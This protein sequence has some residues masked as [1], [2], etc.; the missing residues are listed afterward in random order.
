MKPPIYIVATPIG[1][2]SD[3]SMRAISVIK[4]SDC[5]VCEDTRRTKSLLKKLEIPADK[6][7]FSLFKGVEKKR[8]SAII[9]KIS[10][11]KLVSF[12]SDSGTPLVSDP[13]NLFIREAIKKGFDVFSIPGASAVLSALVVSGFDCENFVFSGF[14][15][16][17]KGEIR[18]KLSPL[19][20]LPYTLVFFISPHRLEK[21]IEA[22]CEFFPK[23]DAVLVRELTKKFEEKIRGKLEDILKLVRGKKLKGEFVIVIS[24]R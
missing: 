22:L 13:G 7:F 8:S 10:E 4:N 24:G 11:C 5:I 19:K 20:E 21:E 1:N 9:E 15:P 16:R 12:V 6:R 17:K 23:R 18:K 2:M 14:L 3:I